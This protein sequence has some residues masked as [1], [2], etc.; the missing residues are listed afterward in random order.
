[1]FKLRWVLVLTLVSVFIVTLPQ[2]G[3]ACS[4]CSFSPN[5]FGFCRDNFMG[6]YDEEDCTTVVAD[7]FSGRT[8]CDYSGTYGECDWSTTGG[9]GGP[10]DDCEW[11]DMN[12]NCIIQYF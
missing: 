7:T 4:L 11:T 3:F 5:H 12:G 1:M 8:T 2:L 6:G 9:P 10:A